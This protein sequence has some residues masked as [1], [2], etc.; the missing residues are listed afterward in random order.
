MT[1]PTQTPPPSPQQEFVHRAAW[2]AGVLGAINVLA[3]VLAARLI[4]LIAV[5]GGIVLAY[6]AL[7]KP[8]WIMVVIL[9]VYCA[10]VVAPAVIL[11]ALG[12]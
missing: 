10:G 1:A 9:G 8:D 2:R 4:V 3:R 5:I 6:P 11:A 12:K 7:G